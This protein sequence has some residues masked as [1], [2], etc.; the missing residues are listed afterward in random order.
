MDCQ[1]HNN[2]GGFCE[3]TEEQEMNLC[4]DCLDAYHEREAEQLHYQN[5][6]KALQRIAVAACIQLADPEVIAS[7]VCELITKLETMCDNAHDALQAVLA[8]GEVQADF[9]IEII[10]RGLNNQPQTE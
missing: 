3:T 4:C 1:F 8:S 6:A 7:T 5:M 10:K 2:C 9:A